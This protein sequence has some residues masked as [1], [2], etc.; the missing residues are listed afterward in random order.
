MVFDIAGDEIKLHRKD[1]VIID[2]SLL[3]QHIVNYYMIE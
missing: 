2:M 1:G 3:I